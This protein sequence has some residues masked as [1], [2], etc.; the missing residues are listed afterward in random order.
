MRLCPSSFTQ[1]I[2]VSARLRRW[3]PLHF[4]RMAQPRYFG[5][6]RLVPSAGRRGRWLPRLGILAR[7]YDGMGAAVGDGVMALA[8]IVGSFSGDLSGL[9]VGRDLVQQLRQHRSI[10]DV[11]SGDLD[12][13]DLQR[14]FVDA[15]V[16]L[17][18]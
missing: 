1:C 10:T 6:Q 4:L 3:Y 18:P 11:A 17:A 13:S 9:H 14:L 8:R 16:D 2:F 5:A 15:N 7:R 12:G